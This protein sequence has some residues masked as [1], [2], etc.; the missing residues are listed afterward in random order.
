MRRVSQQDPRSGF[1]GR[2]RSGAD[3]CE[4]GR[5]VVMKRVKP[6]RDRTAGTTVTKRNGTWQIFK[7]NPKGRYY[8]RTPAASK[9]NNQGTFRC[10]AAK[11]RTINP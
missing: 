3:I 5:Q 6:G 7:N 1:T 11:S 8:A 4:R 2:V 10:Q 9:S